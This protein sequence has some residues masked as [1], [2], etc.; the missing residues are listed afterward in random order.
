MILLT[1]ECPQYLLSNESIISVTDVIF[2]NCQFSRLFER[3]S[4]KSA[5]CKNVEANNSRKDLNREKNSKFYYSR[6]LIVQD[7]LVKRIKFQHDAS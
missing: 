1:D 5:Y 6:Q 3:A 7:S 4:G 2:I